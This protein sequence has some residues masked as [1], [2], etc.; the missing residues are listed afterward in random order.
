M[1]RILPRSFIEAL[2]ILGL[3]GVVHAEDKDEPRK[4]VPR[5]SDAD[6]TEDL[7]ARYDSEWLRYTYPV[8]HLPRGDWQGKAIDWIHRYVP[9]GTPNGAKALLPNGFSGLSHTLR[10]MRPGI[11][12]WTSSNFSTC[13]A[14]LMRTRRKSLQ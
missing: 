2:L 3:S 14:P 13:V 9:D 5:L 10:S 6:K 8:G 7:E 1:I 4:S 12:G 11:D